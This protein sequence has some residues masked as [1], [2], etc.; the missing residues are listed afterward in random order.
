M[1]VDDSSCECVRHREFAEIAGEDA[2]V[3]VVLF[4][5]LFEFVCGEL[6]GVND[7]WQAEV[8]GFLCAFA[9]S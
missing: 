5:E 2:P 8:L 9:W 6:V 4:E 7:G 3:G 1:D